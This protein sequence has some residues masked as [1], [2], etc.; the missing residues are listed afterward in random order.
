[1]NL[2]NIIGGVIIVICIIVTIWERVFRPYYTE[3]DVLDRMFCPRC[4]S[5]LKGRT[6]VPCKATLVQYS[7]YIHRKRDKEDT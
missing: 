3:N 1:M 5:E 6:C 7:M 4:G 2:F